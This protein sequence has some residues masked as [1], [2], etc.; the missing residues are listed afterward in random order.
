MIQYKI[1]MLND[2]LHINYFGELF[3]YNSECV[4]IV[5]GYNDKWEN[6]KTLQMHKQENGFVID[7]KLENYSVLNFCFSNEHGIWD[8][9]EGSNYS[10]YI[11]KN[12]EEKTIQEI[13]DSGVLLISEVKGKVFLPYKGEEIKK[14]LEN[15]ESK[16][17]TA[18]EVIDNVFTKPFNYYNNQFIARFRETIELITKRENMS[19]KDGI[20]LGF[21]MFG[22]RY[23][24]PAIV[25]ACKNL[26]ELNVYLD[27]LD[28]NELDDFKVFNIVYEM[29]PMV[30][31][32]KN[33]FYVE[34][35]LIQKI[36][37]FSKKSINKVK[38][39]KII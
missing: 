19:L 8:N 28:K 13:K 39:T 5:Y 3:K 11:V 22:K 34:T 30:I 33:D 26:D 21:E 1:E 6:A 17:K 25:A 31:K 16:Y 9:N 18:Q 4:N 27:C 37:N 23:L 2:K 14:I 10:V 24:H 20:D 36:I 29:H 15:E 38:K 7:I 35:N 32:N 12:K